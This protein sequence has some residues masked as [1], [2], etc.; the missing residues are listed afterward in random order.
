M[1]TPTPEAIEAAEAGM[2]QR[3]T[4]ASL[5]W[6]ALDPDQQREL[7]TAALSAANPLMVAQAKAEAWDAVIARIDLGTPHM[8]DEK[9]VAGANWVRNQIEDVLKPTIEGK[10]E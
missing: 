4:W 5:H 1:T 9:Y 3:M 2:Y 10:S 7:A 8:V 6:N